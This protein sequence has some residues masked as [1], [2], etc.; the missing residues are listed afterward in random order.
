MITSLCFDPF[1]RR[2]F[3]IVELLVVMGLISVLIALLLP[4]VQSARDSARAISCRNNL[5]QIGLAVH[6][7]HDSH[8]MFPAGGITEGR[9]QDS[10]NGA[11][12]TIAILPYLEQENLYH[13]YDFNAFNESPQNEFV[14]TQSV[15]VMSCPS[16]PNGRRI[17]FPE[18]GPGSDLQYATG[19]YRAVSGRSDGLSR[20]EG[21]SWFDSRNSLPHHW[22]GTMHHIGSGGLRQNRFA[23]ILDGTS[24]TLLVGE[25]A[26]PRC[27][28][29]NVCPRTT[30][31]A[32]TYTSYNQSSMCPECGPRMF[33][34]DYGKCV[35]SFGQGGEHACKR[36]WGS[37]HRAG[38][39]GVWC[40]GSVRFISQDINLDVAGA[41]ATIAGGEVAA[42]NF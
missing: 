17:G 5:K 37:F 2:G 25:Y 33:I 28:P 39:F 34:G 12:W 3:T 20:P 19:S 23:D 13:A 7:Y 30:F 18:S 41:I 9:W 22:R 24:N 6:G 16:D 26:T 14:R 32:Y 4:A 10:W 27:G 35:Q 42:G 11:T 29:E 1:R 36:G 8:R 40:D 21:G 31:W 38:F 15:S